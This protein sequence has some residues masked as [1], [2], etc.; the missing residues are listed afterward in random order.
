MSGTKCQWKSKYKNKYRC[1]EDPWKDSK[2]GYCIF[3][4]QRSDKDIKEFN[5]GIEKKK[6]GKKDYDLR[7]YWFPR[8]FRLFRNHSFKGKLNLEEATFF[9]EANFG[10]KSVFKG[11]IVFHDCTVKKRAYFGKSIFKGPV[12]FADAVFID[13][14]NFQGSTFEKFGEQ[15][16]FGP[17][18]K[19]KKGAI[20]QGCTFERKANFAD[21]L[22]GGLM[23]FGAVFEEADFG[24]STF[25]GDVYFGQSVFKG[26]VNFV[27]VTIAEG[28]LISLDEV[29]IENPKGVDVLFR[30]ARE[31]RRR[32]GDYTRAAEYYYREKV[33]NRKQ[34]PLYSPKRWFE[35]IFFDGLCGYGER[36]LRAIR[37]GLGVLFGLAFL[38]WKVG[39]IYPSPELFNEP[40]HALTFWD[41]LY[42]SVVTFT[43]L[44]FGDWRPDPSHWIR[45]VVMSEAFI[46]AFL[47]ALFIVTFARRMMR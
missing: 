23:H 15:V 36:P 10:E 9:G 31:T 18:C 41:A 39:H 42:F 1:P 17:G 4:E 20:F 44:G 33:I 16:N 28:K 30:E 29:K 7:G 25:K 2:E 26:Q 45:Y 38:Y 22:F 43:T 3:H 46:G 27:E 14:A 21:C 13:V 5:E 40:N 6:L 12:D 32:K 34:L 24:R 35:Y 11:G 37:T 19:F 8:G 47:M